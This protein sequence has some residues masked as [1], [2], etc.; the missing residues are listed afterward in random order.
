MALSVPV[1]TSWGGKGLGS[2]LLEDDRKSTEPIVGLV[3][4]EFWY[5]ITD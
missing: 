1:R 4:G 5:Q 2:Q 3:G